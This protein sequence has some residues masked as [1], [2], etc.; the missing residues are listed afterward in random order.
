MKTMAEWVAAYFG[1]QRAVLAAIRTEEVC[2]LVGTLR[3]AMEGGHKIFVFGNG[4]SAANASHFAIDL[5]KG[6]SDKLGKRFAVL[7]LNDNTSWLTALG[8]DYGFEDS[9]VGQL[10]N[11]ATAGDVAIGL[12]VSGSSANCVKAL[13]WGETGGIADSGVG[14]REARTDGGCGGAG[15]CNRG[16]ALRACGG[17]GDGDLPRGG[18]RVHGAG[19][20]VMGLRSLRQDPRLTGQ[21]FL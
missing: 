13:G 19:C 18:L 14:W 5:G 6:A 10:E 17:C 1:A 9:F 16:Y 3:E 8:N 20:F 15:H 4:G 2:A 11:Y 7:C 21:H 12:S